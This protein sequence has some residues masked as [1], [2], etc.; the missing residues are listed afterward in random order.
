ML[1]Y[2]KK[3]PIEQLKEYVELIKNK[4]ISRETGRPLM[5]DDKTKYYCYWICDITP[6]VENIAHKHDMLE[7]KHN[8]GYQIFHKYLN[9]QIQILSYNHLIKEAEKRHY[10]F[11]E[12][13]NVEKI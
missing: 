6:E 11:F 5:T 7:L 13:L 2:N 10:Q 8:M 4:K 1:E 12:K 9:A 3:D